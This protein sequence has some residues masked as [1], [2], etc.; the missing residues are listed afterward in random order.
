VTDAV[1]DAVDVAVY[2]IPTDAPEA[3]GTLSWDSTTMLLAG[4]GFVL[5]GCR[6]IGTID[7]AVNRSPAPLPR[8]W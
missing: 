4:I 3:D 7:L 8:R 6:R 1:V 5:R 2:T